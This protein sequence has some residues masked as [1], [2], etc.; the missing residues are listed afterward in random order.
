M[1][2]T[3]ITERDIAAYAAQGLNELVIGPDTVLTDMAVERARAAKIRLVHTPGTKSEVHGMAPSAGQDSIHAQI[4]AAVISR[5]GRE[6]EGLD[7]II[8]NILSRI[9]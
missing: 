8:G 3:F 6:P 5:L 4:R 1:P 2:R 9:L 7:T